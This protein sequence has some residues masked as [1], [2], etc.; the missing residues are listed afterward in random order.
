MDIATR[1]SWYNLKVLSYYNVLLLTVIIIR[2]LAAH[3]NI[4]TFIYQG[5]SLSTE[6]A[7]HYAVPVIGLPIMY[8]Q[9]Y[10]VNRLVEKGVARRLNF[11]NFSAVE[12]STAIH[13]ILH[14][15]RYVIPNKR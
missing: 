5:S 2:I 8:D 14:D 15:K 12:L 11:F 3:P 7:I 13:E 10:V 4:K 1:D 9:R 6:E